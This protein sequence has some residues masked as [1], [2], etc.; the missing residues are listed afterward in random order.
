MPTFSVIKH[1]CITS[2]R[3]LDR[4]LFLVV[5]DILTLNYDNHT[6]AYRVQEINQ[7]EMGVIQQSDLITFRPMHICNPIDMDGTKFVCPK[8]DIDIYNEQI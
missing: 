8:Y 4:N 3:D 7:G 6:H 2:P 1:I 5:K